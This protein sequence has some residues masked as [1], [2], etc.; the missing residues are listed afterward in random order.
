MWNLAETGRPY[1]LD[2]FSIAGAEL[3]A[4]FSKTAWTNSPNNP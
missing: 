3:G 2:A 4:T 1:L